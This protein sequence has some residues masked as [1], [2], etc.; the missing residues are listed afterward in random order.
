M[1]H[2]KLP[3][4]LG[5]VLQQT[6]RSSQ[7][8][9]QAAAGVDPMLQVMTVRRFEGPDVRHDAKGSQQTALA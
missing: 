5:K 2:V 9:E 3:W 6:T 4:Q 1:R 8:G 7:P